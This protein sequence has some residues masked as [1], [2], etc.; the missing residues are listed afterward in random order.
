[1]SEG[2]EPIKALWIYVSSNILNRLNY[3]CEIIYTHMYERN[4][5]HEFE[6]GGG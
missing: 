2:M 1:M 4:K 5:V 6:Q 3:V